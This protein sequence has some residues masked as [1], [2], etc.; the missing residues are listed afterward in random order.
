MMKQPQTLK[1]LHLSMIKYIIKTI[2]NKKTI[3]K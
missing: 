1:L 3:G 2:L